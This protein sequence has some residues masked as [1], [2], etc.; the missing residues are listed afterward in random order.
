MK[1]RHRTTTKL[2][3]RKQSTGARVRGPSAADMQEQL[4]RLTREL[5]EA[6]EQ[7]TATSEVLQVISS[8]PGELEPVFKTMLAKA[9]R[10]C[11]AKFGTLYLCDDNGFRAVAMHNA[12]PA[13]AKKRAAAVVAPHPHGGL[14]RVARTKQV[15]HIVDMTKEPPYVE[16]Y[17]PFVAC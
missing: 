9:V 3:R 16:R 5:V 8:S 12:P 1:M 10:I 13:F 14:G 2:K 6:H 17:P 4:D 15:A 7:Q 11:E